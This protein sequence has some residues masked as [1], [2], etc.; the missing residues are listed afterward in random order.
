M[1]EYKVVPA[2]A[3]AAKVKGLKT[4]GDRFAHVLTEALNDLG[5]EGWEFQ[6]TET[7]PCEE[8]K[9]WFGGTRVS[10]QIMMIFRRA[11]PES[12][13]A[14]R[15]PGLR[16]GA[17]SDHGEIHRAGLR[18]VPTTAPI[19]PMGAEREAGRAEPVF[20]PG[21]IVRTDTE[22]RFPPMRKAADETLLPEPGSDGR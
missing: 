18:A 11:L 8:R 4:T 17:A 1:Y 13:V 21:A 9:G 14:A 7:L 20:R 5:A 22:R 3:R 2:P 6:R 19:P 16:A 12:E 15:L 10:T